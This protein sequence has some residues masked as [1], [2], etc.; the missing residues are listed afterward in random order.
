MTRVCACVRACVGLSLSARQQR[1]TS[2]DIP[3]TRQ[4]IRIFQ[5][6]EVM[7]LLTYLDL[8]LPDE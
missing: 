8:L 3:M 2:A 1:Q 6:D 7:M 5:P 4:V